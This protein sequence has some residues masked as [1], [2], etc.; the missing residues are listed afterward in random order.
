M[1]LDNQQDFDNMAD[2]MVESNM[3][4][5][6]KTYKT[7]QTTVRFYDDQIIKIKYLQKKLGHASLS[8]VLRYCLTKEFDFQMSY[9]KKR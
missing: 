8:D 1:S 9:K 6:R 3:R 2:S 7:K 5:I 4:E